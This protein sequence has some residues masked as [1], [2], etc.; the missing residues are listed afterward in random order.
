MRKLLVGLVV[1]TVLLVGC[2]PTPTPEP[3][4]ALGSSDR[5]IQVYFV[6]SVEVDTIVTGGEV[7]RQALTDATGLEFEVFVPT[8]YAA[9]IEGMCAAPEDTMGFP[10]TMAYV[11]AN[12]R[13]GVDASMMAVRHGDP[14]YYSAVI[15]PRDSDAQTLAD[16]NGLKWAYTYA[17]STSGYVVPQIWFPASGLEP[18]DSVAAG[19]HNEA[20]LAV[21]NGGADFGTVYFNPPQLVEGSDL[22]PWESGDPVEPY[23]D[24]VDTCALTEDGKDIQCGDWLPK[25]ARRSVRDT[26]PDVIQKVRL[27]AISDPIPNDCLAFGPDFPPDLRAQIEQALTDLQ[28]DEEMWGQTLKAIYNYDAMI[29]TTD[30]DYDVLR[31]YIEAGGL[32]MDDIVGILQTED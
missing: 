31:D 12:A 18:G 6:P 2:R 9:A 3:E 20:V 7:L 25:D 13:C 30:A 27:L 1:L 5:P 21:Y 15:V 28:A 26:A 19:G 10:A 4:A 22:E 32:S 8:S 29:P 11:V 17:T 24:V 23:A 14:F 16:L